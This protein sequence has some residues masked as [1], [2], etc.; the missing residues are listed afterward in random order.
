MQVAIDQFRTNNLSCYP[1]KK[2]ERKDVKKQGRKEEQK[3]AQSIAILR[4]QIRT[5]ENRWQLLDRVIKCRT[6]KETK[7]YAVENGWNFESR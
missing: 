1:D 5:G 6:E 2:I 7:Y 3:D 4:T